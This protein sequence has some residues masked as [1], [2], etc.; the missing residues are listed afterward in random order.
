MSIKEKISDDDIKTICT[1]LQISFI[2]NKLPTIDEIG[3]AAE[4]LHVG[5]EDINS[6]VFGVVYGANYKSSEPL[7]KL[8][9]GFLTFKDGK[10]FAKWSDLHSFTHG[11]HW[12][13]VPIDKSQKIE[14]LYPD[15]NENEY[16]GLRINFE[17]IDDGFDE[18]SF[19]PLN[20]SAKIIIIIE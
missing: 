19:T 8:R 7:K 4:L 5:V 11:T 1:S 18:K 9:D 17:L 14:E 6:F 13:H 15:L 10:W 16:E 2:N 3:K 12:L 20:E